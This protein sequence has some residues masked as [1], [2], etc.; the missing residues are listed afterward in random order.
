M[1]FF[2]GMEIY[3]LDE[4]IPCGDM[5]SFI[6]PIGVVYIWTASSFDFYFS[7]SYFLH[8]H[9]GR[10]IDRRRIQPNSLASQQGSRAPPILFS[11]Y[12][13]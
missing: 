5:F 6:K 4:F 1:L 8:A 13:R 10:K 11:I 9:V 2:V 3:S 7:L 12:L